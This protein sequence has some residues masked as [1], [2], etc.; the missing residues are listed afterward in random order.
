MKKYSTKTVMCAVAAAAA[1]SFGATACGGDSDD[2]P[3]KSEVSEAI[4]KELNKEEGFKDLP[5]KV[6]KEYAD[7]TAGVMLEHAKAGD[8]KKFVDGDKK[9]D[10][11]KAEKNAD[12][13][14]DTTACAEKI[15]G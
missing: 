12:M 2:A 1:L 3:S 6:R 9:A 10:D 15:A 13:E 14:K 4:T 8:V 5:E 11:V 7:C